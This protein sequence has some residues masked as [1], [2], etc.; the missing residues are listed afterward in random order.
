MH[1]SRNIFPIAMA[2]MACPNPGRATCRTG[3]ILTREQCYRFRAK[4]RGTLRR[5][6]RMGKDGEI[7]GAGKQA[8]VRGNFAHHAGIFVLHFSL[9]DAVTEKIHRSPWAGWTLATPMAG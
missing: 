7:S 6:H 8:R 3:K 9:N 2:M 1:W 5:R 4:D